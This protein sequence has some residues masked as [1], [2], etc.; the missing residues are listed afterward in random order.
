VAATRYFVETFGF[1]IAISSTC[2]FRRVLSRNPATTRSWWGRSGWSGP[3]HVMLEVK[4]LNDVGTTYELCQRG[5]QPR[6]TR[7]AF[8]RSHAS[9]YVRTPGGFEIEYGWGGLLIDDATRCAAPSAEPLGASNDEL[10]AADDHPS[11][12]VAA[13]LR[14]PHEGGMSWQ[15]SPFSRRLRWPRFPTFRSATQPRR[16]ISTRER[17]ERPSSCA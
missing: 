4:D 16:S 2:R 15:R 9:F 8:E 13:L 1:R 7:P 14:S 10:H 17:S 12:D 6:W 11:G 5:V 3:Y